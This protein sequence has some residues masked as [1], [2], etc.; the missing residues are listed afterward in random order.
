MMSSSKKTRLAWANK[1]EILPSSFQVMEEGIKKKNLYPAD[2]FEGG[3]EKPVTSISILI[4][5]VHPPSRCKNARAIQ[6]KCT[7]GF[8]L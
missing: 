1:K 2:K 7:E 4:L 5:V 8:L 6:F 3:K